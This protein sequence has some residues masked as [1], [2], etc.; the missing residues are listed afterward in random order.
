MCS[1]IGETV[2]PNRWALSTKN[3][4][5]VYYTLWCFWS[6]LAGLYLVW[7]NNKK[8]F[9]DKPLTF[10]LSINFYLITSGLYGKDDRE[11]TLIDT[12]HEEQEHIRAGYNHL[13]REHYV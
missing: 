7:V 11:K 1:K 8:H 3:V 10:T 2:T 4:T 9:V 6:N 12:I 5:E 13:I